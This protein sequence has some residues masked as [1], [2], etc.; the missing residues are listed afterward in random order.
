ME[1]IRIE[2]VTEAMG[3]AETIQKTCGKFRGRLN[4]TPEEQRED[5]A[6][7][8]A[9]KEQPAT[10]EGNQKREA[11]GQAKKV[12]LEGGSGQQCQMLPRGQVR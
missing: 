8:Q 6:S 9:G 3:E 12:F 2:V 1:G 5:R 7:T 11:P 10:W 4:G